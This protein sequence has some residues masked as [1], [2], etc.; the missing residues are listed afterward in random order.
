MVR[1]LSLFVSRFLQKHVRMKLNPLFSLY[2]AVE[3]TH[4]WFPNIVFCH[5]LYKFYSEVSQNELEL[6]F[7]VISFRGIIFANKQ[8]MCTALKVNTEKNFSG[9]ELRFPNDFQGDFCR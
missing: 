1:I 2:T 8:N 3:V 9:V 6:F 5:F 7:A 4:A